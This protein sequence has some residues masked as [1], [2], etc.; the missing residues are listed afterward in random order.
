MHEAFYR[1]YNGI[2][3]ACLNSVYLSSGLEG[4]GDE[5]STNLFIGYRD[6][7]SLIGP[8]PHLP[9]VLIIDIQ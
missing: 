2:I 5:T 3:S 1:K 4:P 9:I 6:T 7:S 8:G